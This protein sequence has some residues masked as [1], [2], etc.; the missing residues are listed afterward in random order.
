[1]C[2]T[3][4]IIIGYTRIPIFNTSDKSD[5]KINIQ[6]SK[7]TLKLLLELTKKKPNYLRTYL[8]K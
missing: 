4:L 7:F 2:I 5:D 8:G 1:M 3:W 6:F